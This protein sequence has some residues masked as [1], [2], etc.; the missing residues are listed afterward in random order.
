[1]DN[2]DLTPEEKLKALVI[3]RESAEHNRDFY[4][5]EISVLSGKAAKYREKMTLCEDRIL[6]LLKESFEK[7]FDTIFVAE[8]T[9]MRINEYGELQIFPAKKI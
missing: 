6:E 7:P 2:E 1:M 9:A 3:E 5:R 8:S 4:L